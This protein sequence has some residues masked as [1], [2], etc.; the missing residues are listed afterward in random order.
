M[1][2]NVNLKLRL[3]AG[4]FLCTGVIS[5]PLLPSASADASGVAAI[6][7]RASCRPQLRGKLFT[8]TELYFGLSKEATDVVTEEEFQRFIDTQITP[9]FPDGLT[10]LS[11]TGQFRNSSGT[12]VREG[13]KLLILLHRPSKRSD[14]AIEEIREAYKRAFRQESVLRVDEPSCVSF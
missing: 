6:S 14:R 13:S 4:S 8:R 7:K 1:D 9:R 10:L 5:G 11:G 3:L 2:Q 12:I